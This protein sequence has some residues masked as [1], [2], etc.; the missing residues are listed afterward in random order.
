MAST[1]VRTGLGGLEELRTVGVLAGLADILTALLQ[2]A[3]ATVFK[4]LVISLA[5][6][7]PVSTIQYF[8]GHS[9]HVLGASHPHVLEGEG[10]YSGEEGGEYPE[11][12][13][14]TWCARRGQ[15]GR[16]SLHCNCRKESGDW[17]YQRYNW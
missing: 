17:D 6:L 12:G 3:A 8:H 14:V 13:E 15:G 10:G 16:R 2:L 4:L 11:Y 9:G 5:K 1:G 7:V